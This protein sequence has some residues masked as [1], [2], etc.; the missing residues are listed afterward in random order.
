MVKE[1][2]EMV[3][4][5]LPLADLE[6]LAGV[7]RE[8]AVTPSDKLRALVGE[9]RRRQE[10]SARYETCLAWARE[11]LAPSILA[12]QQAEYQ[13]DRHSELLALIGEALPPLIAALLL[14]PDRAD[15]DEPGADSLAVQEASLARRA[16]ALAE[17][18]LR[19]AV[20]RE[21]QCYNPRVMDEPVS[22]LLELARVVAQARN[23]S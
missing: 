12:I 4:V 15:Q 18:L 1:R 21:P 16:C 2:M 3:G 8:G 19:L 9:A 17:G 10:G 23:P 6:W 7:Q 13:Q 20:S 14:R 11:L 22:R 5:R